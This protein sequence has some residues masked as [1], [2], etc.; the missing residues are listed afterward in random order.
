[1]IKMFDEDFS[2]SISDSEEPSSEDDGL[3]ALRERRMTI[4]Q[5]PISEKVSDNS[6]EIDQAPAEQLVT[7]D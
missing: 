7:F 1:M 5:K 6:L 3:K 2:D 4:K